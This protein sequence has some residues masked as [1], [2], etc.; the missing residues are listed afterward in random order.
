MNQIDRISIEQ[1]GIPGIVLMENAASCVVN[2]ISSF[3]GQL[4]GKR[5]IVLAGKG[6]NGGDAF[7]V[8]RKLFN[9][10]AEIRLFVTAKKEEITGDAAINISIVEKIDIEYVEIISEEQL[11][12]L[13]DS[14]NHGDLVVDGLLGTGLKG[15]VTGIVAKIIDL[16]NFSRLPVIAIDIPSGINGETGKVMGVAVKAHR[17]VTFG[18]PKP[19]LL[20]HPGCEYT[21]KLVT[22][23]IGIPRKVVDSMNIKL[24]TIEESLVSKILPLRLPDTNKGNYGRI[25]V[26]GGS[27]GM[28]GAGGLTAASALRAGAGLVYLGLPSLIANKYN[29]PLLE[30]ITIPIE[31]NKSG[32]FTKDG[33]PTVVKQMENM[34][35]TVIGPGLS[36]KGDA[37]ELLDAIAEHAKMPIIIDADG[38]NAL[39]L[40]LNI[41]KKLKVP[42]VITPHPGEMSRLTGISVQEVQNNRIDITRDFAAKWKV[43]TVLKG[44]RTIVALPDGEAYINLTGNPGMATAGSGDVLTGIIA[45]LIG[46]GIK[47]EEAAIAGVYLHGFAGD[48]VADVKGIYGLI[49]S[50]IINEL[51]Y[52][53]KAVKEGT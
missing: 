41:L 21:G 32:Y 40:N 48:R 15:N 6:N 16:V 19:G 52:A 2:E 18:L 27:N 24:N 34:T 17:T 33:I 28:T 29:P 50:D 51:P 47:P 44:S 1:F 42:T 37:V 3:I 53:I 9:K 31:D 14:L 4:P 8:A 26:I 7:A 30:I 38:L 5:V 43:I 25:F 45:G 11:D 35:V 36:T 39:A 23:D 22:A 12:L 13:K 20:I 46:Q 49:A 10:G